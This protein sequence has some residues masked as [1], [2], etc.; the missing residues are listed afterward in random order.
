MGTPSEPKKRILFLCTKAHSWSSLL[1][2]LGISETRLAAHLGELRREGLLA[3]DKK[4]SYIDTDRGL[5]A[6]GK[7]K[8]IDA[9]AAWLETNP[10]LLRKIALA[11]KEDNILRYCRIEKAVKTEILEALMFGD[12]RYHELIK[13]LDRPDRTIYVN[14]KKLQERGLISKKGRG[15]YGITE[16]GIN[17]MESAAGGGAA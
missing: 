6:A 14:L 4:G 16:K 13:T 9:F 2:E 12:R 10:E 8:A 17:F 11:E 1:K 7:A 5:K 15:L 3:K